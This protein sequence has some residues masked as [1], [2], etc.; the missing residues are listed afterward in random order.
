MGKETKITAT[1]LEG[2]TFLGEDENGG[3]AQLGSLEGKPGIAPM[4]MTL[5]S[6]AACTGVDVVHILRKK[7]AKLHDLKVEVRAK[8]ADKHPKVYTDIHI[9]YLLWGEDLNPK[10]IEKAIELSETKYCSVSIMLK[11]T[12]QIHS[13]YRVFAPGESAE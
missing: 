9:T 6:L 13:D 11:C 10:D 1:W 4:S 3:Q 2:M 8:Q 12:A 7:R 5:A